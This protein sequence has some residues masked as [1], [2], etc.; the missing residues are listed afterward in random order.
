VA[1]P[2]ILVEVPTFDHGERNLPGNFMEFLFYCNSFSFAW[3][4]WNEDDAGANYTAINRS[5]TKE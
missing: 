3:S 4:S 5:K 2:Q 1:S